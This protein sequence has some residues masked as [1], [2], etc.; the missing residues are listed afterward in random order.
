M[1]GLTKH[2]VL[3]AE[4]ELFKGRAIMKISMAF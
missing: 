2:E 1:M 3:V 4:L